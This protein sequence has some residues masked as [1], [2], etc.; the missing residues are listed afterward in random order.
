MPG[1]TGRRKLDERAKNA[2]VL[3]DDSSIVAD[4]HYYHHGYFDGGEDDELMALRYF[5]LLDTK[6]EEQK[7]C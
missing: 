3:E 5:C 1:T 4:L 2:E 6:T 7:C